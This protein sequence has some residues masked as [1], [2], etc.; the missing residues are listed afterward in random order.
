MVTA[1]NRLFAVVLC[2]IL[3][4]TPVNFFVVHVQNIVVLVYSFT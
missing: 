4:A 3:F 1:L 2:E